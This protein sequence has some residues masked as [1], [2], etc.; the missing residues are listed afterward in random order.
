MPELTVYDLTSAYKYPNK[1][2]GVYP[3][4]T[5]SEGIL[6]QMPGF[7]EISRGAGNL[8]NVSRDKQ[9]LKLHDQDF[10]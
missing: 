2:L 10:R 1:H 8:E 7:Y 3:L 9:E 5:N 6:S 4:D